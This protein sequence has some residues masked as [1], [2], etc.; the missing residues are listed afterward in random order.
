MN[1]YRHLTVALDFDRTFTS[2]VDLWRGVVEL[3]IA[4]GHRIV[5]ITGRTDSIKNRMELGRVFGP[6]IFSRLT[7]VVFCNHS[8]KRNVALSRGYKIDIWIDDLPEGVGAESAEKFR[9]LEHEF[10]VFETLPI[11]DGNPVSQKTILRS[12]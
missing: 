11:L 12:F 3:F 9:A 8:P 4:R 5:C 1:P 6:H 10:P 2:D 7:A